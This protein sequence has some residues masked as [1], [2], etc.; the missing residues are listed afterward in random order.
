MKHFEKSYK[1]QRLYGVLG[2]IAETLGVSATLLRCAYMV[3]F[4][5]GGGF[6]PAILYLVLA[7]L[8]PEKQIPFED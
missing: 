7:F 1:N 4:F 8:M 5:V 6:L 2:G 3:F